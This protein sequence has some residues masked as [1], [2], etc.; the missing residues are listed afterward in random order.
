VTNGTSFVKRQNLEIRKNS[1]RDLWVGLVRS[2]W[3][4]RCYDKKSG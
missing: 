1:E 2:K 4:P 3:L